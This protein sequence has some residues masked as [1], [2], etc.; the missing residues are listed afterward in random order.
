MLGLLFSSVA[1]G[2]SSPSDVQTMADRWVIAPIAFELRGRK[3]SAED[4]ARIAG[5]FGKVL[6]FDTRLR[7]WIVDVDGKSTLDGTLKALRKD[8]RVKRAEPML[9]ELNH[10]AAGSRRV[11]VMEAGLE[12]YTSRYQEF[13]KVAPPRPDGTPWRERAPRQE[14][15][16]A[17]LWRLKR[18]ALPGKTIDMQAYRDGAQV[19]DA[20]PIARDIPM[21]VTDI[22]TTFVSVGPRNLTPHSNNGLGFGDVSGRVNALAVSHVDD[23]V[24]YAGTAGGGVWKTTDGGTNWTPLSDDWPGLNISSLA[25]DPNNANVIYA[26]GGD[27]PNLY[28]PVFS[29][30]GLRKSTDG[31]STWTEIGTSTF[32]DEPISDILVHPENSNIV[33]VV[34]ARVYDTNGTAQPDGN[35][36]RSTNGGSTWT[37]VSATQGDYYSLAISPGP[38]GSRRIYCYGRD[39]VGTKIFRSTDNGATFA[40]TPTQPSVSGQGE[41]QASRT[42]SG[43]VYTTS[44]LGTI[45]RSTDYGDTW[46]SVTTDLLSNPGFTSS[47]S[48]YNLSLGVGRRTTISP[49]VTDMLFVGHIDVH[50]ASSPGANWDNLSGPGYSNTGLI[51]VDQHCLAPFPNNGLK[52]LVGSDGGVYELTYN[53]TNQTWAYGFKSAD[54]TISQFYGADYHPTNSGIMLGGLQDNGTANANGNVNDW[55]TVTGYDGGIAVIN[56][57]NT[58]IQV[59]TRQRLGLTSNPDGVKLFRTDNNWV[60]EVEKVG[61]APAVGETV[62]FIAP[63]AKTP[64]NNDVIYLGTNYLYRYTFSTDTFSGRLGNQ[65]FGSALESIAVAPTNPSRIYVGT[66]G[67]RIWMTSNGGSSWTELNTTNL[68]SRSINSIAVHPTDQTEILVGLGGTGTGPVYRCP[69]TASP[70]WVNENGSYPLRGS[71]PQVNANV[72][73]WDPFDP[74]NVFYV[75]TDLGLYRTNAGGGSWERMPTLP[76]VEVTDLDY[77][78]GTNYLMVATYGR[79]IWRAKLPEPVF[80]TSWS[81][82]AASQSS[83]STS[84]LHRDDA[85]FFDLYPAFA[86]QNTGFLVQGTSPVQTPLELDLIYRSSMVGTMPGREYIDLYDWTT[87]QYVPVY[88]RLIGSGAQ[89]DPVVLNMTANIS[90]YIQSVTRNLRARIRVEPFNKTQA[91]W[92]F[93]RQ[94]IGELHWRI[95]R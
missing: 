55:R 3:G 77:V 69:N 39:T 2:T 92:A 11:D 17:Q 61:P 47:Q 57:S 51:H 64:T 45:H 95:V 10:D 18:R 26:G 33:L 35:I 49:F 63:V 71:L 22:S 84:D 90:K 24:W 78:T 16:G 27:I 6:R 42:S 66:D 91:E 43:T 19:H 37:T 12:L 83:G 44:S 82:T 7:M 36:Y 62:S 87:G 48:W 40:A 13:R 34:T 20:M 88:S 30:P 50:F 41:I 8:S 25:I 59:S 52:M 89:D 72:V 79:G 58:N 5:R 14:A 94:R 60:S 76:N 32:G 9:T 28:V 29:T 65:N 23:Q 74:D 75:G 4:A 67:G 54:F 73:M 15:L 56:H 68:P 93:Q 85:N 80:V 81:V 38:T 86:D 46:T 21:G 31:G 53:P 1:L 70:T